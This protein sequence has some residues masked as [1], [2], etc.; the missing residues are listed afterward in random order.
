MPDSTH[1]IPRV[2]GEFG[3]PT[4]SLL[5]RPCLRA[6][7]ELTFT[8]GRISLWRLFPLFPLMQIVL[9]S[10]RV[11]NGKENVRVQNN[12]GGL[13]FPNPNFDVL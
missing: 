11:N 10:F 1:F 12:P 4:V 9:V 13:P 7:E 6:V 2:N 3:S 5:M 8:G